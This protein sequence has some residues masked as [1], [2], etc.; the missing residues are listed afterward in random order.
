MKKQNITL[1]C[2]FCGK[3]VNTKMWQIK[4]KWKREHH[5][6]S[7][8]CYSMWQKTQSS[9]M[10]G[11]KHTQETKDKISN[12][13]IGIPNFALRGYRHSERARANMSMARKKYYNEHPEARENARQNGLGRKQ[14]EETIAKR[15]SKNRGQKRTPE[16]RKRISDSIPRGK[17]SPSWRGGI[18]PIAYRLRRGAKFKEWRE[19]VFS[20]DNYT[21]QKCGS[22]GKR[23]HPHHIVSFS[24]IL[25][26]LLHEYGSENL[27]NVALNSKVLW[28]ID[29]GV[30]LCEKCHKA[31]DSYGK[32]TKSSKIKR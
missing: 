16:Q 13:K 15:V 32:H 17:D 6:C 19:S 31:T 12:T 27:Y 21:C 3:P 26:A 24:E 25:H 5:F 10:L 8:E 18:S 29:N 30:T 2:N 7:R 23:L 20:R 9:N 14:S 28:D 22:H 1:P 4:G 11:K